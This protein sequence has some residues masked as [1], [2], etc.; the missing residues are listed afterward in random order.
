MLTIDQFGGIVRA[1]LAAAAGYFVGKG[2]I[3]A[4]TAATVT[5]ALATLAIT[6]WSIWTNRPA[7]VGK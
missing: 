3:D 2:V 7:K 5:G 1:L 6:A 4:D